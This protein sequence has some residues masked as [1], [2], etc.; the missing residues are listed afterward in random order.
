MNRGEGMEIR[1]KIELFDKYLGKRRLRFEAIVIGG[2]ALNIMRVISRETKDVDLI[3]PK[4]P[5]EI[6]IASIDFAKTHPELG[7]DPEAWMNNGPES[8]LTNLPQ[9]WDLDLQEIYKGQSLHLLTLGRLNLLRTKL[10]AYA[11]RDIDFN[12]CVA[13]KPTKEEIDICKE[14]V[15][16]GDTN[17]L[18]T[19]RVETVL[20]RLLREL[21]Y[22]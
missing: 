20:N 4:I 22:E 8:I 17:P 19:I 13:M 5:E 9:G 11:D 12:D 21:G 18:W 3:S 6:K 7:L 15:L 16:A 14:W 2:A 10:Y 1:E